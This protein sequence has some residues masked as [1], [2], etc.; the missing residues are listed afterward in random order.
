MHTVTCA[1]PYYLAMLCFVVKERSRFLRNRGFPDCCRLAFLRNGRQRNSSVRKTAKL[2]RG[3]SNLCPH[4]V[5]S[6]RYSQRGRHVDE[7]LRDVRT[8]TADLD[9]EIQMAAY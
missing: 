3:A 5:V 2:P 6:P 1:R 9:R 8:G 7:F 4:W